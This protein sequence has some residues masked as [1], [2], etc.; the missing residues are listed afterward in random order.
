MEFSPF[1][2]SPYGIMLIFTR[3]YLKNDMG[4]HQLRFIFEKAYM[5]LHENVHETSLKIVY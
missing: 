5:R 2:L 1:S 3:F 4:T